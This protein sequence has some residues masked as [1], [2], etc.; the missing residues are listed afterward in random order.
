M[1]YI[2]SSNDTNNENVRNIV[3]SKKDKKGNKKRQ[4][5]F[6]TNNSNQNV[7]I[8][9]LKDDYDIKIEDNS[10]ENAELE[11]QH[12]ECD[13]PEFIEIS[14]SVSDN[15]VDLSLKLEENITEL[16]NENEQAVDNSETTDLIANNEPD[17]E[18]PIDNLNSEH[19]LETD[20]TVQKVETDEKDETAETVQKV[21]TVETDETV[22]TEDLPMN[23]I[24]EVSSYANSLNPT[25]I[26][27]PSFDTLENFS[28]YIN[29]NLENFKLYINTCYENKLI[30]FNIMEQRLSMDEIKTKELEEQIFTD[31][32]V[33]RNQY[34]GITYLAYAGVD[35]VKYDIVEI[36]Y[37]NNIMLVRPVSP[38]N[39]NFFGIAV[40][41]ARKNSKIHIL[42][43]GICRVKL[44]NNIKLPI[45]K[46]MNGKLI[47]LRD[48]LNN[49]VFQD[50]TINITY[51]DLL[52]PMKT[53]DDLIT[54]NTSMYASYNNSDQSCMIPYKNITFNNITNLFYL[55]NN[56]KNLPGLRFAHVLDPEII[57]NT[58]LVRI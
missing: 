11:G 57:N 15:Q 39:N 14:S 22:E 45:M 46:C 9:I 4:I 47:M 6:T 42:T 10:V 25:N 13:N 52:I 41:S 54:G 31:T 58:I 5:N 3:I 36:Y 48:Q 20:E 49:I 37:E 1:S 2:N 7:G 24:N 30:N 12:Q 19:Q 26:R 16:V 56:I 40:N 51:G 32:T 44:Y 27:N 53:N 17:Q 28:N 34:N 33:S 43:S 55:T 50:T 29:T 23:N 35:I 38:S 8:N 18:I 21:E